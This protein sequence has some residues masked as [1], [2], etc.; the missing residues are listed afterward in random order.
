MA[1]NNKCAIWG[2]PATAL[3]TYRD[4]WAYDS[5]R[6]GGRYFISGSAGVVILHL[7]DPD[8]RLKVRLT[9]SLV[10]Q[11][12]HGE[13]CPE[14][15]TGTIE[16]VK[17]WRERSVFDRAD[18]ILKH[19]SKRA[20]SLGNRIDFSIEWEASGDR[21][22]A[23]LNDAQKAYFE[24]L[25]HSDSSRSEELE[26]LLGYLGDQSLIER[27]GVNSMEQSC[28]LTFS[29]YA[30]LEALEQNV[31]PSSKAFVAMWFDPS[32]KAARDEG[33]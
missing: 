16:E 12:A 22:E 1:E 11:R 5:P 30:R 14:I 8:D 20:N 32:M 2:T 7:D 19:L 24:L 15:T 29:G 13:K 18:G 25:A 31:T 10:E 27:H 23:P 3:P 6:V 33:I 28:A 26:F 9:T 17:G 21:F 4:G